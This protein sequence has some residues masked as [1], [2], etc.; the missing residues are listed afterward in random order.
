MQYT[1]FSAK[2]NGYPLKASPGCPN[3][4]EW[5]PFDMVFPPADLVFDPTHAV[6]KVAQRLCVLRA[7]LGSPRTDLH[8][9]RTM[10]PAALGGL[11][12]PL[13]L[14][15]ASACNHRPGGNTIRIIQ[16]EI[17]FRKDAFHR[18]RRSPTFLPGHS[19]TV[20]YAFPQPLQ[21][22]PHGPIISAVKLR[23]F[24]QMLLTISRFSP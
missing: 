24:L 20:P 17:C 22:G 23:S 16:E 14:R 6:W 10:L 4:Q 5:N 21:S 12:G 11:R 9:D 3:C 8:L 2:G 15:L 19:D 7:S 1:G 13:C 18:I